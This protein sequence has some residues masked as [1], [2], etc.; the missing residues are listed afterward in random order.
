M[1]LLILLCPVLLVLFQQSG[2]YVKPPKL[3]VTGQIKHDHTPY[4]KPGDTWTLAL[5]GSA[6]G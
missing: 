1:K 6:K 2:A 4:Q 3:E 5:Y